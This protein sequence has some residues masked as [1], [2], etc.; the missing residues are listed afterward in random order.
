[1]ADLLDNPP[2]DESGVD[3]GLATIQT[4][5]NELAATGPRDAADEDAGELAM[6][7]EDPR[8]LALRFAAVVEAPAVAPADPDEGGAADLGSSAVTLA[9][10]EDEEVAAGLNISP[11]RLWKGTKEALR[12]FTYWQMKRRAGT[13]GENGLGPLLRSLTKDDGS[14]RVHLIGHSFGA[15]LVSFSLKA[16]PDDDSPVHSLTLLEGAFSHSSFAPNVPTAANG[17]GALAGQATKVRG[18]ITAVYS[19]FDS[20]VGTFYPLASMAFGQDAS[21]LEIAQ[22]RWGAMGHDGAQGVPAARLSLQAGLVDFAAA[23][24]GFLN[25]DASA[26]VKNGKPPSGAHSDIFHQE[27]AALQLTASGLR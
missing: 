5:M 21:G 19:S 17:K 20:A 16:M 26:V 2:A 8:K 11:K 6:L 3:E 7:Q 9:P 10:I 27:L 24:P 15:R 13:V 14:P 1:L 23:T 25:V 12:Q 18:P 4:L 22:D